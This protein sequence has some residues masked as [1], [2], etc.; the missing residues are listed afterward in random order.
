MRVKGTSAWVG[1][2]ERG[3]RE[4]GTSFL[5]GAAG[6]AVAAPPYQPAQYLSVFVLVY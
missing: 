6:E 4:S 1:I 2:G 3:R 5:A